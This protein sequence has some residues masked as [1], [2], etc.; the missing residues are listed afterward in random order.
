M[1][2][3]KLRGLSGHVAVLL[4][5]YSLTDAASD[6]APGVLPARL[7]GLVGEI[8]GA[9]FAFFRS[10]EM[11]IWE[12]ARHEGYSIPEYPMAGCGDAKEFLA[13]YG[14]RDVPSW[15]E[16]RGISRDV[17]ARFYAYSCI[18]VRNREY[19]RKVLLLSAT[20]AESTATLVPHLLTALRFCD[21]VA[22]QDDDP[23]LFRC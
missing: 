12:I 8:L 18:M 17:V 22:T 13:D 9:D 19:W 14:V 1:T 7:L 11:L 10:G 15:Y 3:G 21:G 23:T 20:D 5:Q 4:E 6:I 2:S 16:A